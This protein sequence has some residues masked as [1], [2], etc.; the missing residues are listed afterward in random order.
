MI[1]INP[2]TGLL[3]LAGV[4]LGFLAGKFNVPGVAALFVLMLLAVRE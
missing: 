1:W 2:R 3:L 4:I